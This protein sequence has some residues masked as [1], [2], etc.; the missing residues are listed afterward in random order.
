MR[1]NNTGSPCLHVQLPIYASTCLYV[2]SY[3]RCSWIEG[4]SSTLMEV[5]VAYVHKC[6]LDSSP[7]PAQQFRTVLFQ[8]SFRTVPKSKVLHQKQQKLGMG[9]G[10]RWW[11]I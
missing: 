6:N 1:G 9:R 8:C 4:T 11:W 7:P 3:V 5:V 2:R 10:W